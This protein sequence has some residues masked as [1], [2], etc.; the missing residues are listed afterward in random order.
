MMTK[1]IFLSFFALCITGFSFS[2]SQTKEIARPKLVIGLVIDQMR[3]DYLY[4]YYDL[5]STNGF[6]RLLNEGYSCE[7]TMIPYVPTYTAPG[8][9]CIFTGSVPAINGIIGNNWFDKNSNK[10]IYCTDDSTVLSVGSNS[11]AGKMS[12][13]KLLTTTITDELRL[14]NNFKSKVIGISLKDRASILPA[15]HSAN[16]AYWFDTK[17]GD[18]ITSSY[19]MAQ[20][21]DWMNKFNQKRLPD[22]YMS[23]DWNTLLPQSKY[24]LSTEDNKVYERTIPGEKTTIFPHKLPTISNL[25]YDAFEYTPF[26][27]TYTFDLA[28]SVIENEN[29][30]KNNVA[31]FLTISI[32]ST[33]YIGHAF[34]P[35]SVETE[36]TYLRLDNDIA[37][38]LKYLDDKLGKENYLL[39]LTADHGVAH[40][41]AFLQEHKI[42][43]G[44]FSDSS[45]AKEIDRLIEN[46]FNIKNSVQ[47]VLNYQVYLN[48]NK[49]EKEGKAFEDVAYEVIKYLKQK[50]F[51]EDAF[52]TKNIVQQSIPEPIK[53]MLVNGYNVNRSG[54]IQFTVAPE[55]FDWTWQGT[56]HGSWNPYDAHI[57]LIWFGWNIKHGATN[58]ETYMTDIA[59]TLAAMLKIQMPS[60]SVGKVIEEVI[61]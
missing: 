60:G 50:P 5:Y 35:N 6:K 3:W 49:I 58:R 18:W 28:K 24:E 15:G 59:P 27:M 16:A 54:D 40:I 23:K 19:Y 42:P 36:D 43:A 20:L 55:Y 46:K 51:I 47:L 53:R 21:P 1:K 9:T 45:L 38:F 30:G 39:F 52:E 2:Q 8:H 61:K 14:S 32:S 48:I 56:T 37:T 12:P 11:A 22:N 17:T 57:P 7:N 41:P 29:L 25:K 31:D 34:G 4:R 44:I 26:G 10:T 13:R 33:D